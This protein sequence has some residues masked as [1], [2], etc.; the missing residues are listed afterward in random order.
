MTLRWKQGIVKLYYAF[1]VVIKRLEVVVSFS[2][3]V[4]K[5]VHGLVVF[6]LLPSRAMVSQ[7]ETA[8]RM[9]VFERRVLELREKLAFVILCRKFVLECSIYT[10]PSANRNLQNYLCV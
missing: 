7:R 5:P 10:W 9:C 3:N 1:S 6:S 4:V 8:C 2:V